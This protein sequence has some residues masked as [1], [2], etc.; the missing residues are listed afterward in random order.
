MNWVHNTI[1]LDFTNG[2]DT[3][4]HPIEI[5]KISKGGCGQYA[6]VFTSLCTISGLKSRVIGI[7]NNTGS[8]HMLSEVLIDRKW[9][10]FDTMYN[11]YYNHSA[12]EMHNNKI[13]ITKPSDQ[14]YFFRTLYDN[15]QMIEYS[16]NYNLEDLM[17]YDLN[18]T[19]NVESKNYKFFY[20]E[21]KL[22]WHYEFRPT[23]HPF[24][25]SIIIWAGNGRLIYPL[26]PTAIFLYLILIIYKRLRAPK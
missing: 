23:R 18:P 5:L 15:I 4:L 14:I 26:L 24:L 21:D 10:V 7:E 11:I 6:I 1:K 8:G 9:K 2:Y 16:K 12:W 13:L 19:L 22:F 20:G 3:Y 17:L 25:F